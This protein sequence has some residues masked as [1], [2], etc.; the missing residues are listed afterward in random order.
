[1]ITEDFSDIFRESGETVTVMRPAVDKGEE[2]IIANEI[3]CLIDSVD[4]QHDLWKASLEQGNRDIR[5]GDILRRDDG[6]ELEVLRNDTQRDFDGEDITELDLKDYDRAEQSFQ[7]DMADVL[8]DDL[9]P[10]RLLHRVV[11]Q[12]VLPIFMQ[13]SYGLA[14][15]EAFKQ[16]EVA[17]R[18]AGGYAETDYGTKL[19]RMAF[20]P[21]NGAL[22][23]SQDTEKQARSDLFA[24]AIGA[25][26]NPGSHRDVEITAEEAAGLIVFASHLLRIV[27]LRN[28]SD[29]DW[30]KQF[31]NGFVRHLKDHESP[32]MD[33]EVFMGED[34]WGYPRYI[35]FNIGKIEN[36]DISDQDAFWL[37]ASTVHAGKVY[38]KLHMNDSNYFDRLKSQKAAI[39]REFGDPLKWEPQGQGQRI[40]IGVDIEVNRLDKN[41]G[42]WNQYFEEMREKT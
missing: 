32:L 31:A 21:E 4:G 34:D 29:G 1:M 35:G 40:R 26:K 20:N 36:L 7:I 37:V 23:D 13:G 33:P 28:Q 22:T 39:E 5:K 6:S 15:F 25:Y 17:V 16:V 18:E 42:Q 10:K 2:L 30:Q 11:S 8:T 41:R 14:V 3:V 9:L 12:K 24:G 27:D 19:M 38:L